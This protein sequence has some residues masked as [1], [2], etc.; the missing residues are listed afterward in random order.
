LIPS[1]RVS[2][3]NPATI[4][5]LSI[6]SHRVS[7]LN[8]AKVHRLEVACLSLSI[9]SFLHVHVIENKDKYDQGREY[10]EPGGWEAGSS[11]SGWE[12][13]RL[14]DIQ[15]TA[16]SH[17]CGHPSNGDTTEDKVV[18]RTRN[19]L[20]SFSVANSFQHFPARMAKNFGR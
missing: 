6:P 1:H 2:I 20:T 18:S 12:A 14:T 9:F 19:I 10:R 8:P 7:I 3:F 13:E 4:L 15:L 17:S 16:V 5:N 11:H